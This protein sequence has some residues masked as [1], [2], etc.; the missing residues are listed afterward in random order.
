[1]SS[2]LL[3]PP[4]IAPTPSNSRSPEAPMMGTAVAA[5]A[6]AAQTTTDAMTVGSC[7]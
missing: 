2:R 4:L 6:G 5:R 1:M 3:P 7:T